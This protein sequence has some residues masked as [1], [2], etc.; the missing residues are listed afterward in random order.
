MTAIGIDLGTTHCCVAVH[1]NGNNEVI[2]NQLGNMTTPS[3]V[4]FTEQGYIVGEEAK[5][6]APLN[7]RNT[8][9]DAKRLIGR[10]FSDPHVTNDRQ[11]WPF[12]L[13][14][15]NGKPKIH[16]R[17][18]GKEKLLTPE[19]VAALILRQLKQSA[20]AFLEQT[21][22]KAVI[23]VPAYFDQAQ[24]E[25]TRD[26]ARIAGL[27]VL[28]IL[29]EPT[30]AALAYGLDN[31]QMDQANILVFDLGGGTVDVSVL[32]KKGQIFEVNSTA[33]DTHLGG[34][35]FDQN[36]LAYLVSEFRAQHQIDVSGDATAIHRLRTECERI[37]RALSVSLK[38]E[39]QLENFI[40]DVHFSS[41]VTRAKF[42]EIN[43]DLFRKTLEPLR[44]AL[45]DAHLQADQIDEIVLV[46]GSTRI[47]RIQQLLMEFFGGRPLNKTV[48]PDEVV[49]YG[50]AIH[51]AM[52]I[53]T[54]PALIS[55]FVDVTP[56][57]IG[58]EVCG[59]GMDVII[60]R[61]TPIPVT[62]STDRFKT[63]S[64]FQRKVRFDIYEGEDPIAINN[65]LLGR[66]IISGL[67]YLKT[68][69]TNFDVTFALDRDGILTVSAAERQ[70]TNRRTLKID[71]TRAGL[72]DTEIL[73]MRDELNHFLQVSSEKYM[74]LKAWNELGALVYKTR[75]KYSPSFYSSRSGVRALVDE[76]DK[77]DS[78]LQNNPEASA[79]ECLRKRQHLEQLIND[80][81]LS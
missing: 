78:W 34:Q 75:L 26:A 81:R 13:V 31:P 44:R 42:E 27:S 52:L 77:V 72:S 29:N 54:A 41:S 36:L 14:D 22:T 53:S 24:R 45:M 74:A 79:A 39:F 66:F 68:E 20:E 49:A 5:E 69:P 30:A 57:S 8:I 40:G 7:P 28:R 67:N 64:L 50:A 61:N 12:R 11:N 37:K 59:G 6:Q 33:G 38:A 23:T 73:R 80:I 60:K 47:P 56:L 25:A 2:P 3:Y 16:I 10:Y 19:E 32:H 58:L 35:D 62:I 71:R 63:A 76:C 17:T 9:Y 15:V 65:R 21:V 1:H 18:A 48:N 51:A 46:G 70:T 55:E 4:A 43:I